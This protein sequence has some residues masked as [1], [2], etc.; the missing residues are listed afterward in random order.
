MT[1]LHPKKLTVLVVLRRS[2]NIS[3]IIIDNID[4][5]SNKY[6]FFP[7]ETA[8]KRSGKRKILGMR[9]L[10]AQLTVPTEMFACKINRTYIDC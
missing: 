5:F 3:D 10:D 6:T 2:D 9:A 4:I 7:G 8:Q 1:I